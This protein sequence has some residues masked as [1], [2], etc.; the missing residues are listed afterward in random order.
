M[1]QVVEIFQI[2]SSFLLIFLILIHSVKSE[3]LALMGSSTQMFKTSSNLEKGLNMF[4]GSIAGIFLITSAL[5]GWGI[6]K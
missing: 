1:V 6:I 5:L 4:T 2:I 3:G